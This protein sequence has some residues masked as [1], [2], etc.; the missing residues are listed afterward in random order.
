MKK[1]FLLGAIVAGLM[2]AGVIHFQKN[3][4]EVNISIDRAKLRRASGKLLD[5]GNHLIDEAQQRL[6]ERRP[7]SLDLETEYEPEIR[8]QSRRFT[9]SHSQ[10]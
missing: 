8:S 9:P 2:A 10:R 3:G 6:N 1:I 4:D 7:R 5:E